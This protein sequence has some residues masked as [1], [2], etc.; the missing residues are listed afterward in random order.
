MEPT[1]DSNAIS[2]PE[3]L[4]L[5][6]QLATLKPALSSSTFIF[7]TFPHNTPIL[8]SLP[9]QMLFH[10]A[11]GMTL[12]TTRSAADA[13]GIEYWQVVRLIT[14]EHTKMQSMDFMAFVTN[15][16]LKD[17]EVDVNF[18]SGYHQDYCFVGTGYEEQVMKCLQD[19]AKE[20]Q[21]SR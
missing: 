6:Q 16:L 15:R 21:E 5:P 10:E 9:V 13:E 12:V 19:I 11:E 7:A 17:L 2:E 1:V 20:A 8:P 4:S 3:V 14:L 18:V